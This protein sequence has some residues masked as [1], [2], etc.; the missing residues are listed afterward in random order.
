MGRSRSRS[1]MRYN[2]CVSARIRVVYGYRCNWSFKSHSI[3]QGYF[4]KI[5]VHIACTFTVRLDSAVE[6][7]FMALAVLL[8]FKGV[9]GLCK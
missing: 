9:M 3:E 6:V 4:H 8:P 5:N 1:E 2:S 7:Y